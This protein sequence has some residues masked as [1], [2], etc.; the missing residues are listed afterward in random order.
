VIAANWIIVLRVLPDFERFQPVPG[1]AEI[2][3]SRSGDK[4]RVC[5]FKYIAPS[6]VY[7]L[8]RRIYEYSDDDREKVQGLLSSAKEVYCLTIDSELEKL[9]AGTA[10]LFIL[11]RRPLFKLKLKSLRSGDNPPQ[12]ILVSNRSG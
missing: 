4:F 7:Y 6:L 10:Q 1:I 5:Y 3:K 9:Q 8:H 11:A 2:I 12:L